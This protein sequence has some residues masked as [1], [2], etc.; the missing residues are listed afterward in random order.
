MPVAR[1]PSLSARSAVLV[2]LVG[3]AIAAVLAV[4]V[5]VAA[6]S[7]DV[8]V[9]LG[10]DVFYAGDV[11]RISAEIADRGPITYGNPGGQARPI[12]LQHLGDDPEEGW[13]AL[14]ARVPD[15]PDCLVQWDVDA[16]VFVDGCDPD[17]TFPADGTGLTTI[18]TYVE[19]G[20]VVVDLNRTR[21]TDDADDADG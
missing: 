7:G 1:G 6:D 12:W 21:D 16:E 19:D 2:G 9:R 8:E 20:E 18:P 11:D 5:L 10:D 17:R 4:V 13:I 14:E 3:V 15:A